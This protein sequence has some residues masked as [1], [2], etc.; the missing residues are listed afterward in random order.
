MIKIITVVSQNMSFCFNLFL[1]LLWEKSGGK[2]RKI[3]YD[4]AF[5]RNVIYDI[6]LFV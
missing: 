1:H 4:T 3:V 6:R 2:C 5:K